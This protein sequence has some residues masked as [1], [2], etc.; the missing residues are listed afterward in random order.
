MADG[1]AAVKQAVEILFS[2]ERFRW[3]IYSPHFGMQWEGLIG[4]NPGYAA[5]EIQRRAIDAIKPDQRMTGI[6]QFSYT[7]DGERLT[8]GFVVNTVYGDVKQTV[9]IEI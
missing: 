2:V 7:A 4:Q 8:V 6:S 5:Q 1:Y 9:T 3:Q